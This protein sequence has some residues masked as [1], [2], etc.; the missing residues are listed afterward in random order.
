MTWLI[1]DILII[2][3]AL[4]ILKDTNVKVYYCEDYATNAELQE[5]YDITVPLYQALLII[6]LSIMPYIN[7]ILF[8]TFII[9]Y[10]IQATWDP[11][12]CTGYTYILSLKGN[13]IITKGLIKVKHLLCKRI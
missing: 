7:I 13:N 9:Y 6:V 12:N 3:L 1:V 4:S 2:T 5:E 8:A 11:D 10:A